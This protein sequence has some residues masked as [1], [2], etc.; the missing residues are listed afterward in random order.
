MIKIAQLI[1]IIL[2]IS[3]PALAQAQRDG[4][5]ARDASRN[6]NGQN[7]IPVNREGQVAIGCTSKFGFTPA[8]AGCIVAVLGTAEVNKCFNDGFGGSGCFGNN[9]ALRQMIWN[10]YQAAQRE[11]DAFSQHIRT[12]TGI[13]LRD[14]EERGILGGDNSTA[15]QVC[16]GFTSLFGGSCD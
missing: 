14:I 12:V 6:E 7:N 15:R 5:T 4:R 10:N 9:N 3:S 8:G 13:S 1:I 11:P 16:N 2:L